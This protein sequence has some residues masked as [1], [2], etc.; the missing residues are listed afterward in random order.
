MNQENL[1]CQYFKCNPNLPKNYLLSDSTVLLTWILIFAGAFLIFIFILVLFA[2]MKL[3]KTKRSLVRL[4]DVEKADPVPPSQPLIPNKEP[5]I[6]ELGIIDINLNHFSVSNTITSGKY[7]AL[8]ELKSKENLPKESL[9]D[10]E[11]SRLTGKFFKSKSLNQFQR[12][13]QVY[14]LL[15]KVDCSLF[16]KWYGSQ[17]G[18]SQFGLKNP[19]D[20]SD[21]LICLSS[22]HYGNLSSYLEN[23]TLDWLQLSRIL[24]DIGQGVAL[25]HNNMNVRGR[26]V[27]ICHRDLSS[28]NV[29]VKNDLSCCISNFDHSLIFDPCNPGASR[30]EALQI[31]ANARYLAPELLDGCLNISNAE[32]AL[33]Q[34]DV[35]ALALLFWETS[36][37]CH[38]LYQGVTVP[39]FQLPFEAEVGKNEP[40]YDQ[41]RILVAKNRARPLFPEVWKDSNPAIQL[42]KDTIIE[43]WDDDGEARLTSSCIV[44]RF[45]EL[46]H[47]WT[48]Y[49]LTSQGP[50]SMDRSW[51]NNTTEDGATSHNLILERHFNNEAVPDQPRKE[52]NLKSGQKPSL[53]IQPHQG[54]NP[55][56]ERNYVGYHDDLEQVL[57]M[58]SIKDKPLIT[59]ME[60]PSTMPSNAMTSNQRRSPISPAPIPYLQNDIRAHPRKATNVNLEKNVHQG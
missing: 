45:Q 54:L 34:V 50:P 27:T 29:L 1:A 26:H 18:S 59:P 8:Y 12:E 52:D 39:D 55:C 51:L 25:L 33:R 48:K 58:G 5:S 7:A 30:Q 35:Y 20:G 6:G 19:E 47:L 43:S 42:L 53:K 21:S 31:E 60:R 2:I 37:R 57:V 38:D 56:L 22:F 11:P 41:M 10:S 15:K 13:T 16:L 36:R 24:R 49:R 46:E 44:E 4:V 28:Y 14:Q 3:R 40:T 32:N 17:Q 23:H 9:K